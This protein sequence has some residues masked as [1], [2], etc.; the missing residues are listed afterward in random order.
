MWNPRKS[1]RGE[2]APALGRVIYFKI[3][4]FG[5]GVIVAQDIKAGGEDIKSR[6]HSM[7][8]EMQP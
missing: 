8:A 7:R 2:I 6:A 3:D 1:N 4:A 5:K